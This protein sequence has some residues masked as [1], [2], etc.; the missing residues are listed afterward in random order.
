MN[1]CLTDHNE[2]VPLSKSGLKELDI[3][4]FRKHGLQ[5]P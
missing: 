5:Y 3:E 2:Y 1:A 4:Q